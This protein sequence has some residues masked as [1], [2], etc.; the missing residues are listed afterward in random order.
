MG[1]INYLALADFI[2]AE[3]ETY[4][5]GQRVVYKVDELAISIFTDTTERA[6]TFSLQAFQPEKTSDQEPSWSFIEIKNSIKK[7][8]D[9]NT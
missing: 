8:V 2:N 3:A 1:K 5:Q 4:R 7:P 6:P 9:K